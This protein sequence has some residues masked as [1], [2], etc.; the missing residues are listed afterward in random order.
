[1]WVPLACFFR[2]RPDEPAFCRCF[3]CVLKY[4]ACLRGDPNSVARWQLNAPRSF[5]ICV[6]AQA[7]TSTCVTTG[8]GWRPRLLTKNRRRQ[9]ALCA[10]L[11]VKS[12][13]ERRDDGFF[14]RHVFSGRV[15]PAVLQKNCIA[16][17]SPFFV[18]SFF[19]E[20]T[21]LLLRNSNACTSPRSDCCSILL[22]PLLPTCLRCLSPPS[23]GLC[24]HR[25]ITTPRRGYTSPR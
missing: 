5:M 16:R 25:Q 20:S 6:A 13:N 3:A 11:Y 10:R 8:S 24:H 12:T 7:E 4:R 2:T 18:R 9:C 22:L 23:R 14:V 1:M 21:A 17:T 19:S 15:W